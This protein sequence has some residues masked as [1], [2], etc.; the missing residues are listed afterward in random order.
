MQIDVRAT[1]LP[2]SDAVATFVAS[3][4]GAT[5]KRFSGTVRAV[6]VTLSDLNGPKGGLDMR[7]HIAVNL[8]NATPV[9]IEEHADDLY[10][11]IARAAQRARTAVLRRVD[12]HKPHK[13]R[14][15]PA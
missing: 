10:A 5:L 4:L 15:R 8:H 13:M 12:A 11:A 2:L 6:G 3:R 1:N 9:V 7:C 14:F